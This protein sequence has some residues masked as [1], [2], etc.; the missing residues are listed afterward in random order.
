MSDTNDIKVKEKMASLY[1]EIGEQDLAIRLY[2][3]VSLAR[4]QLELREPVLIMDKLN[5]EA[6]PSGHYSVLRKRA[7]SQRE[8][9]YEDADEEGE[10]PHFLFFKRDSTKTSE[11]K[12]VILSESR[13]FAEETIKGYMKVYE[14]LA[15]KDLTILDSHNLVHFPLHLIGIIW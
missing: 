5:L 6:H 9:E 14:L 12:N 15:S 3:E 13:Q 4:E 2:S 11:R 10:K 7:H 1:E 8:E